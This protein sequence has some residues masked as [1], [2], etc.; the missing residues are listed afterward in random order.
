LH[1]LIVVKRALG[2]VVHHQ[3]LGVRL[4]RRRII[5]FRWLGD[6]EVTLTTGAVQLPDIAAMRSARITVIET[7]SILSTTTA[8]DARRVA[9]S[10]QRERVVDGSRCCQP[11]KDAMIVVSDSCDVTAGLARCLHAGGVTQQLKVMMM[12]MSLSQPPLPSSATA[13]AAAATGVTVEDF[14][15]DDRGCFNDS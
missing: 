9:V 6:E 10:N 3:R 13:T 4:A 5:R 2:Y 15:I 8:S 14:S 12:M 7:V 1:D 11:D